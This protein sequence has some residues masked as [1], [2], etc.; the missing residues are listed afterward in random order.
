M[1]DRETYI[2]RG[3]LR[4]SGS[5]PAPYVAEQEPTAPFRVVERARLLTRP[6]ARLVTCHR[7]ASA[8]SS[9][10]AAAV[11]NLGLVAQDL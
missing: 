2:S 9:L 6:P 3:R 5:Y 8:R 10:A 4:A 1:Q 11:S 7:H